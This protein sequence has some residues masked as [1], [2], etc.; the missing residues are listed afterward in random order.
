MT[1]SHFGHGRGHRSWNHNGQPICGANGFEVLAGSDT[2]Q[3]NLTQ[4]HFDEMTQA[5]VFADQLPASIERLEKH[6]IT[7]H[8]GANFARC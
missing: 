8:H 2:L 5:G 6:Q 7:R 1:Y 3:L 4:T